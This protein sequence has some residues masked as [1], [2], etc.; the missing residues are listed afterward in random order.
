MCLE[1]GVVNCMNKEEKQTFHCEQQDGG[2]ERSDTL[3]AP[4]NC[5]VETIEDVKFFEET[6][7]NKLESPIGHLDGLSLTLEH[8]EKSDVE[9]V[10]GK[11]RF[12]FPM[13]I[14]LEVFLLYCI[15]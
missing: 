6:Q 9:Q 15:S 11:S 3:V 10:I 7:V 13:C 2:N 4:R 1:N 5:H 14:E 12:S 8:V